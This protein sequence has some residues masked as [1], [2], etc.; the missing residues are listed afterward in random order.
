MN[1]AN[2]MSLLEGVSGEGTTAVVCAI[3]APSVALYTVVTHAEAKSL[4]LGDEQFDC[5]LAT[6]SFT[7]SRPIICYQVIIKMLTALSA[8]E[9][10]VDK[11]NY[12]HRGT[13]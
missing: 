11:A 7:V 1:R 8:L 4:L 5:D 13:W 2:P 9:S 6:C 12:M 3:P 10:T